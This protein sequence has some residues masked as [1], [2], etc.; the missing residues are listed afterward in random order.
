[1]TNDGEAMDRLDREK[2]QNMHA[3]R[4]YELVLAATDDENAAQDARA[5][6][7][8]IRMERKLDQLT[9]APNE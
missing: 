7:M 5:E 8:S 4:Y 2:I 1:M 6:L 3:D 9:G